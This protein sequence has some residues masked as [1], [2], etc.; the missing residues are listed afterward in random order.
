MFVVGVVN[1]SA[2][3]TCLSASRC[4]LSKIGGP[5]GIDRHLENHPETIRANEKI[6]LKKED[7]Y[8]Q[9]NYLNMELY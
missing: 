3:S 6:R 2:S 8:E 4:F 5:F 9:S 7:M 1:C